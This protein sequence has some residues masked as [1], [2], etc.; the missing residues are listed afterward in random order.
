MK[1]SP[2]ALEQ[3]NNSPVRLRLAI[4]LGCTERWIS[5]LIKGNEPNND[6]TKAAALQVIQNE[7]GLEQSDILEETEVKA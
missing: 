1:L 3:I 5:A 2:Q 7:T 4:A 6:L